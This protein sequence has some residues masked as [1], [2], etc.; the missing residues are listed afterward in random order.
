MDSQTILLR[1]LDDGDVYSQIGAVGACPSVPCT[2]R[3]ADDPDSV[4]VDSFGVPED[5]VRVI[6]Q[7]QTADVSA[8]ERDL[9]SFPA[10]G[11]VRRDDDWQESPVQIVPVSTR[12]LFETNVFRNVRVFTAGLGSGGAP[13]VLELA[14]LGMNQIL[15]DCDRIEVG[16]VTRHVAGLSDVGRRKT[17]VLA[18]M[19]R[20]KNPYADVEA[21]D[22]EIGWDKVDAVT[23]MI[24][25]S[26]LVI[27]AVDDYTARVILNKV[28]VDENK[29]LIMAG[30]FRRAY[31]GQV[32]FVK[33]RVT[34]CYQCLLMTM[35]EKVRDQEISSSRSASRR[36]YSDLDVA[37]EPGLS[38]DIAPVSL[39]V[40]KLVIQHLLQGKP[41]TLRSL[42]DDLAASWYIWLNRREPETQYAQLKPLDCNVDGMHVLR[43]YGI[44]MRRD[45]TCP[46]CGDFLAAALR[47]EGLEAG[48]W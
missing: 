41:T 7:R 2:L 38:T 24:R 21:H 30:C 4:S 42:D 16:N 48:G 39:M 23:D 31:G 19:V 32:L 26:D 13:V 40:V 33:P 10:K 6:V 8:D 34:P 17:N 5:E 12:G 44:A 47:A 3:C 18:E 43:W 46:V 20:E 11:Y 37:I 28:C 35:P 1:S 9:W 15:V 25:R 22:L 45:E 29:P 14:K 36:A 27:C